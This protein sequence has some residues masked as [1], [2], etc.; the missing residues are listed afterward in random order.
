MTTVSRWIPSASPAGS[1]VSVT[2]SGIPGP[3]GLERLSHEADFVAV[4]LGEPVPKL[5]IVR[6]SVVVAALP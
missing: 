2:V 3:P 1:S 5:S 6:S 4:Q